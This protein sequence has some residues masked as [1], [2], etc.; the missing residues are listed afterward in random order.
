MAT[1]SCFPVD[2]RSIYQIPSA[3]V[4]NGSEDSTDDTQYIAV[5]DASG[6]MGSVWAY[7]A[8]AVSKFQERLT[9]FHAITFDTSAYRKG[10]VLSERLMDNGG[11]G[12]YIRS[13]IEEMKRLVCELRVTGSEHFLIIFVSD[14]QDSYWG[15]SGDEYEESGDYLAA[16]GEGFDTTGMEFTT[17]GVGYSFPTHVSMS[18]RNTYHQGRV[19][20]PN[21]TLVE[22]FEDFEEQFDIMASEVVGCSGQKLALGLSAQE[23]PWCEP[24][25]AVYEKTWVISQE[26]PGGIEVSSEERTCEFQSKISE[27]SFTAGEAVLRQWINMLHAQA[28]AKR[29]VREMASVAFGL[30]EKIAEE[31]ERATASE[32][33]A[34]EKGGRKCPSVFQRL[35]KKMSQEQHDLGRLLKELRNLANGDILSDLSDADLAQRLAVGTR[36]GKHHSRAL[37]WKGVSQGEF[38]EYME[39]F[40]GLLEKCLPRLQAGPQDEDRSSVSFESNGDIL[41]QEDLREAIQT[42]PSQYH[43]VECVP[44]VGL[45]VLIKVSDASMINP[46]M[47]KVQSVSRVC[48]MIDTCTLQELADA[49]GVMHMSLGSGEKDPMNAV[50]PIFPEEV[51]KCIGPF[52]RSKVYSMLMTHVVSKNIDTIDRDS[53]PA[54]LAATLC[55]ILAEPGSS[56]RTELINKIVQTMRGMYIGREAFDT[57]V[58][59][60]KTSPALAMV[61]EHPSVESRCQALSKPMLLALCVAGELTM[62]QKSAIVQRLYLEHIGRALGAEMEL[63][64]FFT[65]S[66]FVGEASSELSGLG[67]DVKS[68]PTPQSLHKAVKMAVRN[69]DS[70]EADESTLQ[71]DICMEKLNSLSKSAQG[72]VNFQ[73]LQAFAV[74]LC[75]EGNV[76]QVP[77]I[78]YVFHAFQ[79]K[80]SYDRASNPVLEE[81][82]VVKRIV[83]AAVKQNAG[84]KKRKMR[85]ELQEQAARQ[86]TEHFTKVHMD[87]VLPMT[88]TE[89]VETCEA[90]GDG[91]P[92]QAALGYNPS[93]GLCYFS[94]MC[95]SCEFYLKPVPQIIQHLDT[96]RQV[97][98]HVEAMHRCIRHMCHADLETIEKAIKSGKYLQREPHMT[99]EPKFVS[100]GDDLKKHIKAIQEK[101]LAIEEYLSDMPTTTEGEQGRTL[102]PKRKRSKKQ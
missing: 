24:T 85:E 42:V 47:V 92:D 45:P 75:G 43:L 11:G 13:G 90:R 41:L 83:S 59:A 101:Y 36:E 32:L 84:A 69:M 5:L 81:N 37:K 28:V 23:A 50:C 15:W 56:W 3:K 88:W 89:I 55:H 16:T 46:W 4:V 63:L 29:D 66:G 7:V 22:R 72:P 65:V 93:T 80:S 102:E 61:T 62:E 6:S 26:M 21:V 74:E 17:V 52:F 94:C 30:A 48:P 40:E 86:Y 10:R 95:P 31:V 51:A 70:K 91:T 79:Y 33:D 19:N 67:I 64:D 54:L 8:R 78:P 97:D 35:R 87:I 76:P 100:A 12:T 77:Y 2:G 49:D 25:D 1:V 18:L 27:W 57:T 98:C 68:F 9:N 99:F 53:H 82:A 38:K 39:D 60:L 34:S 71:V 20:I 44:M 73:K 58:K 14:G 96:R